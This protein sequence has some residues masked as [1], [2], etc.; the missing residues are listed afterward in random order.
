MKLEFLKELYFHEWE[1]RAHLLDETSLPTTVATAVLGGTAFLLLTFPYR[2]DVVTG[3]FGVLVV[4]A[5][6]FEVATIR[7]LYYAIHGYRYDR[8]ASTKELT[9]READ[10]LDWHKQWG[11]E[12]DALRDAE[13][14]FEEALCVRFAEA[15]DINRENNKVKGDCLHDARKSML[16]ALVFL[17]LAFLPYLAQTVRIDTPPSHV[18]LEEPVGVVLEESRVSKQEEKPAQQSPTVP[19]KEPTQQAPQAAPPKPTLPPNVSIYEDNRPRV[20]LESPRM[21]EQE[22][23]AP[24]AQPAQAPPKPALPPNESIREERPA[25]RR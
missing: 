15:T 14:D 1:R 22:Q 24:P 7:H 16:W 9:E 25:E 21:S 6:W 4:A 23:P 11:R 5:V 8:I 3:L 13:A 18:R 10:L 19:A 12:G 20:K 2:P 17:G